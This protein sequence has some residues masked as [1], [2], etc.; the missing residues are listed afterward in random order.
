MIFYV[1]AQSNGSA[2]AFCINAPKIFREK[3]VEML[4]SENCD[5]SKD[6]TSLLQN[7]ILAEV[8]K[9]Y[10]SAVWATRGHV[11]NLEKV[12]FPLL[13]CLILPF[14][15]VECTPRVEMLLDRI[16]I[17]PDSTILRDTLSI[18]AR[19]SALL[20]ILF[21][22]SS[23]QEEEETHTPTPT[24]KQSNVDG[25]KMTLKWPSF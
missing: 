21:Q 3:L 12:N 23:I 25:M 24:A 11:R 14:C 20:V 16:E 10:D 7:M 22:N 17:S 19:P 13:C 8:V 1:Y 5:V 15:I 4:N 18:V 9:L 6:A 2:V